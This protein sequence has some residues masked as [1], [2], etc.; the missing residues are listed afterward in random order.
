MLSTFIIAL[1]CQHPIAVLES[2][3][4]IETTT[5]PKVGARLVHTA[6]GRY[7]ASLDPVASIADATADLELLAPLRELDYPAWLERVSERGLVSIIY[8]DKAPEGYSTNRL[9]ALEELGIKLDRLPDDTERDERVAQ[10]WESMQ[11]ANDADQALLTGALLREVSL[12]NIRQ[13]RRVSLADLGRAFESKDTELR[14]AACR[15]SAHQ[16]ELAMQHRLSKISLTDDSGLVR[17]AA[18]KAMM[19]LDEER[20]LGRWAV[21]L[22]T[23]RNDR[24][25]QQA[26]EHLGNFGNGRD[27]VVKSRE[28]VEEEKDEQ[29]HCPPNVKAARYQL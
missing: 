25:R 20:A 27:E 19:E 23:S 13:K 11:N 16:Q 5:T 17:P 10:L 22:W 4:R 1:L 7:D 26:A 15:L 18:A 28:I 6:F 29:I 8:A 24:E 9:D 12:S 21:E 3:T 14:R 2:G